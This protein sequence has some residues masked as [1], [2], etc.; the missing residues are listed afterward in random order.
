M[1]PI[2]IVA[3]FSAVKAGISAG[4]DI[5]NLVKPLAKLFDGIDEAKGSHTAKKN[6]PSLLGTS[7]NEEALD[8]FIRKKQAEDIEGQLREIV[9][10]SRG[11][12]AWGELV[13]L[14]SK[15]RKDRKTQQVRLAKEKTE[16]LEMTALVGACILI[17]VLITGFIMFIINNAP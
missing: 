12:S 13:A 9:I 14:R 11:L 8:T 15:I 1:E 5:V 4:Q 16:R 6:K 7:V 17:P 3:A 2:S 10:Y